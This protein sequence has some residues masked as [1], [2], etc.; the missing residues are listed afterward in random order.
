MTDKKTAKKVVEIPLENY[1]KSPNPAIYYWLQVVPDDAPP[2]FKNLYDFLSKNESVLNEFLSFPKGELSPHQKISFQNHPA[3]FN[4]WLSTNPS[5]PASYIFY[6]EVVL[7]Q[8]LSQFQHLSEQILLNFIAVQSELRNQYFNSPESRNF[9]N[10]LIQ[11]SRTIRLHFRKALV[12]FSNQALAE[13]KANQLTVDSLRYAKNLTGNLRLIQKLFATSTVEFPKIQ[14]LYLFISRL[15]RVLGTSHDLLPLIRLFNYYIE[16]KTLN[17]RAKSY[18]R[19]A[20]KTTLQSSKSRQ[21]SA[22]KK[23]TPSHTEHEFKP[24]EFKTELG[25]QTLQQIIDTGESPNEFVDFP[26]VF[27]EEVSK[28]SNLPKIAKTSLEKNLSINSRISPSKGIYGRAQVRSAKDAS[29]HILKR[30]LKL[31]EAWDAL[32]LPEVQH[33]ITVLNKLL[34]DGNNKSL[35]EDYLNSALKNESPINRVQYSEAALALISSLLTGTSL[36]FFQFTHSTDDLNNKKLAEHRV[37]CI[38]NGG[39]YYEAQIPGYK[40]ELKNSIASRFYDAGKLSFLKLPIFIERKLSRQLSD[41]TVSS[42]LRSLFSVET[43]EHAKLILK[44]INRIYSTRLTLNRIANHLSFQL[45]K[46]FGDKALLGL[47]GFLNKDP[48]TQNY[49]ANNSIDEINKYYQQ[50]IATYPF[51]ALSET[52]KSKFL[53]FETI[54]ERQRVGS[55]NLLTSDSADN[56]I[57]RINDMAQNIKNEYFHIQHNFLVAYTYLQILF[58]TGSRPARSLLSNFYKYDAINNILFISDKDTS[59]SFS[60]RPVPVH[61]RLILQIGIL[62]THFEFYQLH[63]QSK[64]KDQILYFLNE[65]N[66]VEP[67]EV[68]RVFTILNFDTEIPKNLFRARFRKLM[69]NQQHFGQNADALLSHWDAGEEFYSRTSGFDF[70]TLRKVYYQAWQHYAENHVMPIVLELTI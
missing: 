54:D 67:F 7:D 61:Q 3:R 65:S 5:F 36:H 18:K 27:S 11:S 20:S 68:H 22:A 10:I 35:I 70:V 31:E 58:Y 49:Y 30:N 33:L 39:I 42:K 60:S 28:P 47:F 69:L 62:K 8:D 4:N 1:A 19:T 23:L 34:C 66:G 59:D 51:D 64:D 44:A 48:S 6:N 43:E 14:T 50:V 38:E 46:K 41:R 45:T 2:D 21:D 16:D 17:K 53:Q 57:Q 26:K 37:F 24:K 55:R 13:L 29:Q 63:Y 9:N 12:S 52:E 15:Q 25:L 32:S 56:E 40:T